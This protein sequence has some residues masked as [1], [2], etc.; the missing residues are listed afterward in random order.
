VESCL[1]F[2]FSGAPDKY[3]RSLEIWFHPHDFCDIV[4]VG[5]AHL[6]YIH[7]FLV[8]PFILANHRAENIEKIFPEE[9]GRYI[10]IF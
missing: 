2:L 8:N 10:F 7:D 4:N 6:A 1:F 9:K 5:W 3:P